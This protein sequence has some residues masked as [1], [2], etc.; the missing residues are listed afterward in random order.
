MNFSEWKEVAL[1]DV[2]DIISG[3][4]P[5]T[6]HNEYWEPAEIDW[7]TAKDVSE[8]ENRTIKETSRKISKKGLEHSAA[9]MLEP[10]TTVLIARGA[11]TGKVALSTENMAMNQ[12]CYG[13]QAKKGN[14]KLFIYY[15]MLSRY[16][17]FRSIANGSIFDTIIGSGI[18]SIKVR[19]PSL[20]TQQWI[21]EVL[22]SLDDKIE[23]NN[24]INKNLEETAKALFKH[25][26]VDFEFPNENG[27]PYKSSGG[28]F[29]ESELGL[30]PKGWKIS[31]LGQVIK[32]KHGFAFKSEN[33]S[34]DKTNRILLTPGNFKIGGGFNDKKLKYYSNQADIPLDYILKTGDMLITMTDLS[35]SG[36][37]LGFP[38]VIPII[39]DS[40]VLHNQRLGRVIYCTDLPIKGYV[41]NLLCSKEYRGYILGSATGSTVKHTAP[42][43][44]ESYK[45]IIPNKDVLLKF[46]NIMSDVFNQLS[47]NYSEN[48]NL[49]MLK[50]TILPKI[51]S[52]EIQIPM[53]RIYSESTD[54][55]L[56]EKNKEQYS[57]T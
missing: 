25:W 31:S 12:T 42:S 20:P 24:S 3:G 36:D 39:S 23:L 1:G 44:I 6:A 37:T 48:S 53:G 57:T 19:I 21:G 2:V 51:M 18:K 55:P 11:T 4:T 26:F 13:L 54:L 10:L 16:N 7:I 35:K 9:R 22:A 34:E 38:A 14:D 8:C 30:I 56:E 50:D 40:E 43:R 5:K 29:E 32:V 41:Y 33:F 15:L 17:S 28:E 52:G 27:D 47:L 49:S 46:D 45:I